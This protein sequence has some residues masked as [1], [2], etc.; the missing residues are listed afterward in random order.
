LTPLTLALEAVDHNTKA[1]D[2]GLIRAKIRG[3][4]H[5]YDQRW[6]SQPLEV[7][8]VEHMLTADMWNP[9]SGKKSR[10]YLMAGKRDVLLRD[11]IGQLVLMDHKTCSEDIQDPNAPY[12]RQLLIE[13]QP[14]YY[15]LMDHLNGVRVDYGLWDVV[16]K[17]TLSPRQVTKAERDSISKYGTWFGRPAE[18]V[19]RETLDMYEA[20]VAYDATEVR[21]QWYFQRRQVARL[22]S[23]LIEV[24]AESWE[25]GQAMLE[26]RK[27]SRHV[28]NAGACMNYGS[29]CKFLGICSGYDEPDSDN[30]TRKKQVHVELPQLPG[31][32]KQFLTVSRIKSFQTCKRKHYYEYELGIERTDAAERE[33]LQFGIIWHLALEA[34]FNAKKAEVLNVN[35]NVSA[36]GVESIV[37]TV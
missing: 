25:I 13:N 17:P 33:T 37:A 34:W 15:M 32:G 8:E 29:P 30:W 31:D 27:R 5:A 10:T 18:P 19:E 2:L 21:S 4:L 6:S 11:E 20:R 9:E 26:E 1:D 24:A 14:T 7:L 22:D 12:W 36:N 35:S 23:Q 28:R 3:L 16:R